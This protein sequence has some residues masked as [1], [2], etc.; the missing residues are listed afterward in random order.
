MEFFDL[1]E[2]R[3]SIRK[4]EKK[5]VE[6]E[7]LKKILEA[8]NS[9]PSAGNLQ[10]YNFFVI[11]NQKIKEALAE[12]AWGQDFIS[13]APVVLVF[14]ANPILSSSKYGTRGANLYSIQDATIACS[15]AQLAAANLGLGTVWVGAFSDEAVKKIIGVDL[16]P[17]AILPIGY[18]A[19][20]PRKTP[21]QKREKFIE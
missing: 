9:A 18:P 12:A 20:K 16:I 13:E 14:F 3:R 17:V 8:A 15:Y 5:K 11:K 21:R 10:S 19:E 7:K 1:I 6:E 2:E 4:F